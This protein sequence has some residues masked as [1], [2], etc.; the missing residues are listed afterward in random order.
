[1]APWTSAPAQFLGY[2]ECPDAHP[3]ALWNLTDDLPNHPCGSTV[4]SRTLREA[5]YHVEED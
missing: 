1:M 5:G 4:T 2:Q 3:V